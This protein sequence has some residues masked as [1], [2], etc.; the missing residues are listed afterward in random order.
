[1]RLLFDQNIS[2]RVVNLLLKSFPE[3]VHVRDL[4]LQK[5]TDKKI[6][7]YAKEKHFSIVTF[8][9][10]FYDLVTLHGH[11]PKIIWIRIGN[12]STINLAAIFIRHSEIISLFL[13]DPDYKEVG[14][15]EID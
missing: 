1:V 2:Y 5:A 11:P 6:W 13:S 3:A 10:D 8:D 15:L 14:C 4:G 7:E 12:T 9:A